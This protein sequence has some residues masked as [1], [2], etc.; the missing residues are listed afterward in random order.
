MISRHKS[1]LLHAPL[2]FLLLAGCAAYAQDGAGM[3][4]S[5]TPSTPSPAPVG[6]IVTW[7]ANISGAT[8]TNLWYR[9]RSRDLGAAAD[10]S[11]IVD[12][13]PESTLDWTASEHEGDYQVEG[14]VRNNDTGE[15]ATTS[16][17]FHFDSRVTDSPV[18]NATANP[19][20]FLYSAPPCPAGSTMR[21]QF[22]S[23]G[24]LLQSTAAKSCD[25]THSMNFYLAGMRPQASHRAQY[26]VEGGPQ[27][28]MGPMLTATTPDVSLGFAPYTLLQAPGGDLPNDILL[29]SRFGTP[30][31]TDLLGN[32]V[33]FYSGTISFLTRPS[34]GG[35]FFGVYEDS[36]VDTAH[37]VLREWDLAGTTIRETNAARVSEQLQA[38]G[39][40]SISA[41]HHEV[42]LLPDGTVLALGANEQI[43][44]NVQGPGP[45]DVLGDMIIVLDSNLQLLWA[46][47]TFD[48]LDTHRMATLNETCTLSNNGCAP[49]FLAQ[50]ANDWV[51]GNCLQL[52]PDGNILY[53]SRHQDWLIKIDYAN[54]QGTGNILWRLG[55]GGDFLMLSNAPLPWFSH[56]HDANFESDDPTMLTLFDNGNVRYNSDGNA[57]SRGQV[58]QIDEQNLT[59]SLV[60]NAD[61]GAFSNALGSAQK[62][63]N[64]DYHFNLGFL[65]DNTA[66]SVEVDSSGAM[67]YDIHVG[68]PEY[69]T[70]R[71]SDLYTP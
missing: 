24:R 27:P 19:L 65:L 64:G 25:A 4:I 28:V 54:G 39:M 60:L 47:D 70:F 63:P 33:W 66:R 3:S 43:L 69:R 62:L 31:A 61:L 23:S 38:L 17:I 11:V 16:A 12:Y 21:V 15:I 14:A 30:V 42:R 52:T 34:P 22:R 59:A 37:E 18:I 5:L 13:G 40:R 35:Y 48:H 44:N 1:H 41:F 71:M 8:S 2:A 36:T 45:V 68:E 9:F 26:V 29:Q 50:Q 67:G 57:H 55:T 10:Y 7:T 56:Q 51:H 6:S 46:W 32:L 53:S 49:F 20:V 58:L